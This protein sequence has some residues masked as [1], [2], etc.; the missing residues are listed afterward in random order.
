ML[1]SIQIIAG[2]F[3]QGM[4]TWKHTHCSYT[5]TLSWGCRGDHSLLWV[6]MYW[7]GYLYV[8]G[9]GLDIYV[10]FDFYIWFMCTR[11]QMNKGLSLIMYVPLSSANY[12]L[13]ES[14]V[15]NLGSLEP[16]GFGESVSGVRR[17]KILSNKSKKK[18][19][20]IHLFFQLRRVRCKHVWNLWGSVPPT[21]LRTTEL[22]WLWSDQ[23][24][25]IP[26]Y[27]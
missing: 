1:I 10:Y 8:F 27:S 6:H 4:L 22:V 14:V 17:Q 25:G 21:R 20:T 23:M 5:R 13:L 11:A 26:W 7:G 16:Q 9:F 18:K 12:K 19:F 15:L 24:V 2:F 3:Y